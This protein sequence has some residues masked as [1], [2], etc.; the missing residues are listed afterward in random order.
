MTPITASSTALQKK[1]AARAV[2]AADDE[3]ADVARQ[4]ALRSVHRID[5][6]DHGAVGHRE[7]QRR[8]QARAL[9]LRALRPRI[10][11]GRSRRSAAAC[12]PSA[13]SLRDSSSSSGVQ[14][15]G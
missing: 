13:A 7:A 2:L 8:P 9:A 5:E 4:E 6:L 3:I 15:Q 11:R 1:N 12:P 14:K 10:V